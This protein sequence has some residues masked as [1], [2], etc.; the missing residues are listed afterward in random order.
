M[1]IAVLLKSK[2]TI[3]IVQ[4]CS[5]FNQ[6]L[7]LA[8]ST[9]VEIKSLLWVCVTVMLAGFLDKSFYF[10]SKSQSCPSDLGRF[11][12]NFL[13]IIIRGRKTIKL[14]ALKIQMSECLFPTPF[15]NVLRIAHRQHCQRFLVAYA[16]LLCSNDVPFPK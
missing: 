8:W 16:L 13:A 7:R 15:T 3:N 5:L 9:L 6:R 10:Y 2:V 12:I 4:H 1:C 11:T 14:L